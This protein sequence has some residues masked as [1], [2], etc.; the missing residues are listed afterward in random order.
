VSRRIPSGPR[1][2][3]DVGV[4][5]EWRVTV[6]D[7]PVDFRTLVRGVTHDLPRRDPG[8]PN[9]VRLPSGVGLTADGW[10]AELVTPPI[11]LGSTAPARIVRFLGEGRA[12]LSERLWQQGHTAEL[13][14]F[15]THLNVTCDDRHVVAA[16]RLLAHR[17]SPAVAL[18]LESADSVGLLVRPRRGRLEIGSD[19]LAGPQLEVA[20]AGVSAIALL[21]AASTGRGRRREP[22][23]ALDLP[24]LDLEITMARERFGHYVD[25]RASGE[26][27]YALGRSTVLRTAAGSSVSAGDHLKAV[28]QL[29]R[30][31]AERRG[32]DPT[33]V[34]AAVDGQTP[35]P[36]EATPDAA[37][38]EAD[39]P[40]PP[41]PPP[42][43]PDLDDRT[44]PFGT[45][46]VA[47]ATWNVTAWRCTGPSGQECFVVVPR[48]D[49]VGF[50]SVLDAGE[51]DRPL[52]RR[53]ARRRL[54]R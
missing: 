7:A 36:C 16:A 18:L 39:P 21:C 23:S 10:E 9:A 14:G 44:R 49:H 3:V 19:H 52:A 22:G 41:L 5:Q 31:H 8:D 11:G 46:Q 54:S 53:L 40:P 17:C 25:R 27:L 33:P 42:D 15:S 26:D 20:I 43:L 12:E 28:W 1:D 24:E 35:L 29:A 50:L 2:G 13:T 38:A 37:G 34:D 45:V 32:L 30:P 48:A 6:G 4:E 51:L 47:W